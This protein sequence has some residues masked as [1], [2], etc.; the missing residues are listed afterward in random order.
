MSAFGGKADMSSSVLTLC[1][2]TPESHFADRKSLLYS[3]PTKGNYVVR[4][5]VAAERATGNL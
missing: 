5:T 3:L 4:I 2:L 1:K